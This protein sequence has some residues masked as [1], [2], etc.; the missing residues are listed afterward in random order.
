MNL[1]L[2]GP[3]GAGKRTQAVRLA[4]K[5]SI[6]Q[7]STGDILRKA[8][9]EK[10]DMGVK[11]KGYMNSGN[12]VPDEIVVGIIK[13]RLAEDDCMKGFILDGFPRTLVQ[14]E[15]LEEMLKDEGREIKKVINIDI[16]DSVLIKRLSGRRTCKK[17]GANYH[18]IFDPPTNEGLCNK[19]NG[20]LFQ[21]DDDEENTVVSRLEVYKKQTAPLIEYYD[22]KG[23]LVTIQ[24]N[25][26]MNKNFSDMCQAVEENMSD[27]S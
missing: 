10:T 14:A 9:K 5:Y 17:C 20:E 4:N 18:I 26:P 27:S 24:G 16:E 6:P 21:R 7:I 23:I 13:E 1:V 3:P 25:N 15:K 11:A 22:N 2:L 8:V 12:L 19:C